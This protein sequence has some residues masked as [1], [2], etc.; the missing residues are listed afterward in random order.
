MQKVGALS[1]CR[2]GCLDRPQAV[3]ALRPND[4]HLVELQESARGERARLHNDASRVC[5]AHDQYVPVS[6]AWQEACTSTPKM[7]HGAPMRRCVDASERSW[8]LPPQLRRLVAPLMVR[9]QSPVAALVLTPRSRRRRSAPAFFW[10]Q[11][12]GLRTV[13]PPRAGAWLHAPRDLF[14]RRLLRASAKAVSPCRW[15]CHRR[16][17]L[18]AQA[19]R[20]GR[21]GR[22]RRTRAVP[23]L[24]PPRRLAAMAV[25]SRSR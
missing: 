9:P 22:Q 20:L 1:R 16:S 14:R 3:V 15:T 4:V 23:P 6:S 13:T 10:T 7:T 25:S 5:H 11:R 2:G 8:C 24:R 21:S 19:E 12:D 18:R 17:A